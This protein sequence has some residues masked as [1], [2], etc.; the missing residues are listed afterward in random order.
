MNDV[1]LREYFE[2]RLNSLE[3]QLHDALLSVKE[4][5]EK[6][7]SAAQLAIDKTEVQA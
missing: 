3:K 7:L 1:P 4:A 5:Q 2:S 6:A